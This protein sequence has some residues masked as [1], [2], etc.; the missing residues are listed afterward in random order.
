M[1]PRAASFRKFCEFFRPQR[2]LPIRARPGSPSAVQA[3]NSQSW[4]DT[5]RARALPSPCRLVLHS[6]FASAWPAA[7]NFVNFCARTAQRI[8]GARPGPE[9]SDMG[10]QADG[11]KKVGRIFA[12]VRKISSPSS[13]GPAS[14]GQ[15]FTKLGDPGLARGLGSRARTENSARS[16]AEKFTKFGRSGPGEANSPAN[17]AQKFTKLRRHRSGARSADRLQAGAA[18]RIRLGLARGDQFCEFLRAHCAENFWCA[19]RT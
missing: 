13:V 14:A 2:A 7:T 17:A 12:I 11:S 8:F 19:P 4:R 15:K 6:E 16:A 5:D 9:A 10:L 18:W 3:R 1:R